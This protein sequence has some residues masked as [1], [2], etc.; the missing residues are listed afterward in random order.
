MDHPTLEATLTQYVRDN[1]PCTIEPRVELKSNPHL[2]QPR[3]HPLNPNEAMDWEF[4]VYHN[5]PNDFIK[6]YDQMPCHNPSCTW[7]AIAT[8]W[9]T[10]KSATLIGIAKC[11]HFSVW[12]D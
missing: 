3:N 2:W 7:D 4:E 10:P 9:Y 6:W 12:S 8:I 5:H 1:Y 11:G